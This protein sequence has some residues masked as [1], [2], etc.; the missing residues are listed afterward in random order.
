MRNVRSCHFMPCG[1]CASRDD[2]TRAYY[3]EKR[4]HVRPCCLVVIIPLRF[5]KY[6]R[7]DRLHIAYSSQY[8]CEDQYLQVV[9]EQLRA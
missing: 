7:V 6:A 3:A 2:R 8:Q 9:H 1:I 5:A 4:T